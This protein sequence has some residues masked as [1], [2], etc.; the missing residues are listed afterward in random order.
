MPTGPNLSFD[1]SFGCSFDCSFHPPSFYFPL[2]RPSFHFSFHSPPFITVVVSL[3]YSFVYHTPPRCSIPLLMSALVTVFYQQEPDHD[4]DH[5]AV[6]PASSKQDA[7]D[8][9]PPCLAY[10]YAGTAILRTIASPRR[11]PHGPASSTGSHADRRPAHLTYAP[12]R[13]LDLALRANTDGDMDLDTASVK[14]APG[15]SLPIVSTRSRAPLSH[16]PLAPRGSSPYASESRAHVSASGMGSSLNRNAHVREMR[17]QTLNQPQD[18][19]QRHTHT[20]N[21]TQHGLGITA[22][23][24]GIRTEPIPL[25]PCRRRAR[26]QRQK[27]NCRSAAASTKRHRTHF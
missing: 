13:G 6:S 2:T 12:A 15:P 4:R 16:T 23:H 27:K 21:G 11:I 17:A 5:S 20:L 10:V 9:V 1:C 14:T 25:A 18:P 19:A 8:Y 7:R 22:L 3:S 26:D 24:G